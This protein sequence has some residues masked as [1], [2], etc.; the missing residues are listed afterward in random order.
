MISETV[1]KPDIEELLKGKDK[2]RREGVN[3]ENVISGTGQ[4]VDL[5]FAII[6][7]LAFKIIM[8]YH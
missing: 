1:W 8:V 4:Y 7:Y 6:N 3:I 2:G 5:R